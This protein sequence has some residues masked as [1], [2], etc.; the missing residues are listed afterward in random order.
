MRTERKGVVEEML[1]G[2]PVTIAGGADFTLKTGGSHLMLEHLRAALHVGD[3]VSVTLRF[4]RA[5][6]VK[7]RVPVVSPNAATTG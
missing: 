3:Q 4:D 7:V 5:G 1:P 2:G 6:T